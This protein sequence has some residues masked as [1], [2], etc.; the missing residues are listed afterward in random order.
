MPVLT[1]MKRLLRPMPPLI[2]L[3]RGMGPR[4]L[5]PAHSPLHPMGYAGR[6]G[7]RGRVTMVSNSNLLLV[8]D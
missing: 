2:Y 8:G 6:T 7:T 5:V 1:D 4:H 3:D